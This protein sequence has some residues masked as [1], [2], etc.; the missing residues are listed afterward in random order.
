LSDKFCCF[1][2]FI[3][4]FNFFVSVFSR[5]LFSIQ[6]FMVLQLCT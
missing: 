1:G 4:V 6:T 2:I 5:F 3:F